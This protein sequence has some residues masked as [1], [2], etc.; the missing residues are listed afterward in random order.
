MAVRLFFATLITFTTLYFRGQY[1]ARKFFTCFLLRFFLGG[2]VFSCGIN[3]GNMSRRMFNARQYRTVFRTTQPQVVLLQKRLFQCSETV[4]RGHVRSL[5]Q[6][7]SI[8]R[9]TYTRL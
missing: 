2:G 5:D 3:V 7:I 4:Y 1:D 6:R 9:T 8:E